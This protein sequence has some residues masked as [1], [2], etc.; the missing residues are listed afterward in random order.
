MLQP[1]EPLARVGCTSFYV[2]GPTAMWPCFK[3][4]HGKGD[5]EAWEPR[6]MG[7][8]L[9][10]CGALTM[11]M[12]LSIS[13]I[14]NPSIHSITSASPLGYANMDSQRRPGPGSQKLVAWGS[15]LWAEVPGPKPIL[16]W[17]HNM[18]IPSE[19]WEKVKFL[20]LYCHSCV[21]GVFPCCM[22]FERPLDNYML[23]QDK[24]R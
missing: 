21:F 23:Y 24:W 12:Q 2:L 14:F 7:K 13:H 18:L 17:L 11:L 19:A 15:A 6:A 10:I 22:T 1:N 8:T 3:M 4:Q 16:P 9:H 20:P 5:A